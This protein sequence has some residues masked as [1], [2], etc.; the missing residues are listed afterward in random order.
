MG[1]ALAFAAI[2]L[3]IRYLS[4]P[5]AQSGY[6]AA[7]ALLGTAGAMVVAYARIAR[8]PSP[9][10]AVVPSPVGSRRSRPD[11]YAVGRG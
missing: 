2:L 10:G 8:P 5:M 1:R 11:D 6:L 4:V 3:A 7:V 9:D